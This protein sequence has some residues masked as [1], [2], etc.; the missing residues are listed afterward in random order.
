MFAVASEVAERQGP[1]LPFWLAQPWAFTLYTYHVLQ[2]RDHARRWMERT[3]R[4]ETAEL[5]AIGFH[6]PPKLQR[7][8]DAVRAAASKQPEIDEARAR[9]RALFAELERSKV[10]ES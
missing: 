7:E 1:S 2:Q 3:Y 5:I 4:L 6:E 8:R 10:M 9:G